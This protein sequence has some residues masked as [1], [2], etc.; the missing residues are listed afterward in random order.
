MDFNV[1]K[2]EKFPI[3]LQRN[4]AILFR[5]KGKLAGKY[6]TISIAPAESNNYISTEFTNHLVIRE[7]NIR[8]NLDIWDRKQIEISGLELNVGYYMVTSKFV[9]GLPWIKT[10]GTFIINAKKKF[11]VFSYKK[12]RITFQD[13]TMK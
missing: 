5:I 7:S 3:T 12:K 6:I 10:L 2:K 13:I 4:V 9:V 8:G 1:E 11:M